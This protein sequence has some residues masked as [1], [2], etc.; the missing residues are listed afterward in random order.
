MCNHNYKSKKLSGFTLVEL[1]IVILIIG[2]LVAG[3]TGGAKL[4]EQ[5]ELRG[6]I[7]DMKRYEVSMREFQLQ[8]DALAGDFKNAAA[9]F[10]GC[11]V[12]NSHCGGNGDGAI[13]FNLGNVLL[14]VGTGDEAVRVFR[15]LYLSGIV[16]DAGTLLPPANYSSFDSLTSEGYFPKSKI[17]GASYV[18]GT[19]NPGVGNSSVN[20][21]CYNGTAFTHA[22][23]ATEKVTSIQIW[24]TNSGNIAANC[25]G[26]IDAAKAYQI[27]KK[28]DDASDASGTITGADTGIVRTK[29]SAT[30]GCVTGSAYNVGTTGPICTVALKIL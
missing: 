21:S 15:H 6:V 22:W 16:A 7:S 10:T 2:I 12:T 24:G 11:T 27:D 25:K 20:M 14:G 8:Y 30:A 17:S 5:A 23:T 9:F 26:G 4:I 18:I 29:D 1:S 13:E 3:I 19:S 28:I